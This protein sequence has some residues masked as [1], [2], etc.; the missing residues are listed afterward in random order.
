MGISKSSG[1]RLHLQC[2]PMP[3]WAAGRSDGNWQNS[4]LNDKRDQRSTAREEPP[5]D[6]SSI[7]AHQDRQ[8]RIDAMR[9]A[10]LSP[11]STIDSLKTALPPGIPGTHPQLVLERPGPY[12][13]AQYNAYYKQATPRSAETSHRP[14]APIRA[15]AGPHDP[16][17][18]EMMPPPPIYA[19][20]A[21]RYEAGAR[22]VRSGD[23]MQP[24][25][26]QHERWFARE[27]TPPTIESK[28]S[29]LGR[30]VQSANILSK[31]ESPPK[32]QNELDAVGEHLDSLEV[33]APRRTDLNEDSR[34][35]SE[36]SIEEALNKAS[37]EVRAEFEH[38]V[39]TR[40]IGMEKYLA[41]MAARK[42]KTAQ[43]RKQKLG[44]YRDR[45]YFEPRFARA[46]WMTKQ[47]GMIE[48][49][50]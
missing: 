39:E 9:A 25:P 47:P 17:M 18:A 31:S 35:V 26:V 34:Y 28:F 10:L 21:G 48:R 19:H 27:H 23:W 16:R 38:L 44:D 11:G 41:T 46:A 8:Q 22:A 40:G 50:I 49:Y 1:T 45:S 30:V 37:P 4:W 33:T 3:R 5:V 13:S 6:N 15:P 43:P 29:E 20:P 36:P 32:P 2:R 7:A 24:T 14:E 12:V 42:A